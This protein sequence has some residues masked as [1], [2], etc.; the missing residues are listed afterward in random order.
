M[1]FGAFRHRC[2]ESAGWFH[3]S[4][5]VARADGWPA[6]HTTTRRHEDTNLK[7]FKDFVSSCRRV[8]VS[9]CEPKAY[10]YVLEIG[11]VIIQ[12]GRV[13]P[14]LLSFAKAA[15]DL[16]FVTAE[17]GHELYRTPLASGA[18]SRPSRLD[19]AR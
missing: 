7:L 2:R 18:S 1:I 13:S 5:P 14:Q 9:P 6:A 4:A 17:Y 15:F 12:S 3:R 11:Y 8:F 19:P 10:I 16:E